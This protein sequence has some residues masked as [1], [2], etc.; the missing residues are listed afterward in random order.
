MKTYVALAPGFEIAEAT[1][2]I[3]ILK[4]AGVEVITV[5]IT[6]EQIV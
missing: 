2:P 1:L 5:S 6:G 4:R 3:D